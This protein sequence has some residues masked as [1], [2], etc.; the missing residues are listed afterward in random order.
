MNHIIS[1]EIEVKKSGKFL[2]EMD[3]PFSRGGPVVWFTKENFSLQLCGEVKWGFFHFFFGG[4]RV[5]EEPEGRE[6][7][8]HHSVTPQEPTQRNLR[9]CLPKASFLFYVVHLF[10]GGRVKDRFSC[11][12]TPPFMPP[13]RCPK[14][15]KKTFRG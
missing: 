2:V 10:R 15:E 9:W 7:R 8:S 14:E 3:F 1:Y 11:S 6:R 4:K 5:N 12:R 13:G